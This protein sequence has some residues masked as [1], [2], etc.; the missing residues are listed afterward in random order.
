M[1]G[2]WKG[3]QLSL[4]VLCFSLFMSLAVEVETRAF[5]FVPFLRKVE[6]QRRL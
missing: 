6:N 3:S 1:L 5:S 4:Q 2:G